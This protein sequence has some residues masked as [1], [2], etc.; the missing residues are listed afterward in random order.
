MYSFANSKA[1][2]IY[3]TYLCGLDRAQ[4]GSR[5]QAFIGTNTIDLEWLWTA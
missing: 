1:G 2:K 4:I 5:I 3:R